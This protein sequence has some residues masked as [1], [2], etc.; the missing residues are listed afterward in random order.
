MIE[1]MPP[2][3]QTRE[4]IGSPNVVKAFEVARAQGLNTIMMTGPRRT[5]AWDSCELVLAAPGRNTARIQELHLIS[6]HLICELI[7]CEFFEG[8]K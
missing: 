4:H 7:D 3:S 8:S 2:V 1:T 5:A 6:Y